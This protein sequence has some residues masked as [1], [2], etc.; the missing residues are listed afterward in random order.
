MV[1]RSPSSLPWALLQEPT[2]EHTGNA[3]THQGSFNSDRCGHERQWGES[4]I[5]HSA[6]KCPPWDKST[7]LVPLG[8][9]EPTCTRSFLDI[10]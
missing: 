5:C 2:R 4:R 7:H 8:V 6:A 3:Q 1:M 9:T 10:S